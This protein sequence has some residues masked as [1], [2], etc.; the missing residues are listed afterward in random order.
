MFPDCIRSELPVSQ[1]GSPAYQICLRA[2]HIDSS[3]ELEARW[4]NFWKNILIVFITEGAK[5]I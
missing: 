5:H 2:I 1:E 4:Y 3:K